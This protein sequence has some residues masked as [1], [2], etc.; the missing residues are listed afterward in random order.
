MILLDF[1]PKTLPAGAS[2]WIV[3]AVCGLFF[4]LTC[5][6]TGFLTVSY[7][8]KERKREQKRRD[9]VSDGDEL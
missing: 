7:F 1:L 5:G 3:I 4:L 9:K 2:G 6:M 8:R